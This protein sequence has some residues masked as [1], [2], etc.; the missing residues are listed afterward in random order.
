MSNEDIFSGAAIIIG[1]IFILGLFCKYFRKICCSSAG[2]PQ[3]ELDEVTVDN[4]RKSSV[5]YEPLPDRESYPE[6]N[7]HGYSVS[8]A[9]SEAFDFFYKCQKG[10]H[11]GIVLITGKGIH[12][13]FGPQ[14]KP[15]IIKM[16]EENNWNYSIDPTNEGRITV[17]F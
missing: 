4:R 2:Y 3:C 1:S 11:L 5:S 12:S 7:L 13:R 10:G 16:A 14:I 6:L 9:C 17:H 8:K 15:A